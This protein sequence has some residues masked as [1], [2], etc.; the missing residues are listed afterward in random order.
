MNEHARAHLRERFTRNEFVGVIVVV[1]LSLLICGTA[2]PRA[3]SLKQRLSCQANLKTIGEAL[4]MYA[5]ES[6]GEFYPPPKTRDC[7]AAGQSWSGAID[8]AGV[9]P[10]YLAD[11]DLLV[12]PSY[13]VGDS[14]VQ[15]WDEGKTT[16]PRWRPVS[17]FS[18]NGIVEPCELL[19]KPYY[20][21]GWA[22]SE[23][24][25]E[26]A[27]RPVPPVP[28]VTVQAGEKAAAPTTVVAF[29][30]HLHT[31][32]FRTAVASM[33]SDRITET[34]TL[35]DAGGKP[36]ELPIGSTITRLR[37]GAARMYIHEIGNPAAAQEAQARIVVMH[38]ERFEAPE[39][40]YHGKGLVNILYM[41]GHVEC[42]QFQPGVAAPFPLNTAGAILHDAVEDVL[43]VPTSADVA[44]E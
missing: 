22:L 12:C 18:N 19:A 29:D 16:N 38:E 20:Y 24:T 30:A 36:L 40:F 14:A 6:K 5:N 44:S 4:R 27:R 43:T 9:H 8:M 34:W 10:E 1:V 28:P 13:P 26:S 7:T 17:G 2:L 3:W 35:M 11:L 25:F 32:R 37:E 15:I 39:D 23:A 31:E 42:R 41:D 21:Y 33:A